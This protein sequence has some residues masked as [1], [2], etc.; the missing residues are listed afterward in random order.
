MTGGGNRIAPEAI[1]RLL[2]VDRVFRSLAGLG[3]SLF[4]PRRRVWVRAAR[5]ADGVTVVQVAGLA[6]GNDPGLEPEVERVLDAVRER[7]G[8]EED[9]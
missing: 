3:V 8:E 4:S 6:R 1:V 2:R 9:R 7:V 5:G